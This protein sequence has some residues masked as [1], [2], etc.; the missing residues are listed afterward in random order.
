MV[1]GV[2]SANRAKWPAAK[3]RVEIALDNPGTGLWCG[4][5]NRAGCWITG[6]GSSDRRRGVRGGAD[7]VDG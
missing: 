7:Q 5:P 2:K 6:F 3:G 4:I 1:F